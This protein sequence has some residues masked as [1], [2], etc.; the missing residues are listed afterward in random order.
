MNDVI[1][2]DNNE[3][4]E[5]WLYGDSKETEEIDKNNENLLK[6]DSPTIIANENLEDTSDIPYITSEDSGNLI[7]N[8]F[9]QNAALEVTNIELVEIQYAQNNDGQHGGLENGFGPVDHTDKGL[10]GGGEG[11]EEEEEE[12]D[13]QVTIRDIKANPTQYNYP[14][15]GM[16]FNKSL[17][18]LPGAKFSKVG[19]LDL[20]EIGKFNNIPIYDVNLEELED[21]PWRKPGADITD[22]FNYGFTEETWKL[23]SEKQ[24]NMRT[25][26]DAFEKIRHMIPGE[27]MKPFLIPVQMPMVNQPPGEISNEIKS[28]KTDLNASTYDAA[29]SNDHGGLTTIAPEHAKETEHRFPPPHQLTGT[30]LYQKHGG[31]QMSLPPVSF[32]PT[33]PPPSLPPISISSLPP[34]IIPHMNIPPPGYP[35]P[36]FLQPD[37]H[38]IPPPHHLLSSV[39]P[40]YMGLPPPSVHHPLAGLAPRSHHPSHHAPYYDHLNSHIRPPRSYRPARRYYYGEEDEYKEE[41][42]AFK[43]NFRR[44]REYEE[45]QRRKYSKRRTRKED[46]N[47]EGGGENSDDPNVNA[48]EGREEKARKT[49]KAGSKQGEES[50]EEQDRRPE[51][52]DVEDAEEVM[53]KREEE[54]PKKPQKTRRKAATEKDAAEDDLEK[55][56]SEISAADNDDALSK[57]KA[58]PKRST[59]ADEQY[60]EVSSKE[61]SEKRHRDRSEVE[62]EP[63]HRHNSHYYYGPPAHQPTQYSS[64]RRAGDY[65]KHS[66]APYYDHSYPPP[67]PPQ[68]VHSG[69]PY[70][71]DSYQYNKPIVVTRN[72]KEII[73]SRRTRDDSRQR[74]S[75]RE[76]RSRS[77]GKHKKVVSSSHRRSSSK[78]RSK[79]HKEKS[80]KSKRS[81]SEDSGKHH[82]RKRARKKERS[83]SSSSKYNKR[84]SKKYESRSRR[85][86]DDDYE[87]KSGKI[88]SSAP[89]IDKPRTLSKTKLSLEEKSATSS[90]P[91]SNSTHHKKSENISSNDAKTAEG[92]KMGKGGKKKVN[93]T[94]SGD[95]STTSSE[96]EIS[97]SGSP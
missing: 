57:S 77:H 79:R 90:G 67:E 86:Y 14:F 81:V 47:E 94:S 2:K 32:D 74:R 72:T 75:K 63:I 28:E 59:R 68:M 23:Y 8:G 50:E 78:K 76:S 46:E 30:P 56:G 55:S 20:E 65:F 9:D 13:V 51:E 10:N 27:F 54:P 93:E 24:K 83:V 21:K 4:D 69:Q 40:Q 5:A 1:I 22:Y 71:Y 15:K 25:E 38:F 7:R 48:K 87:R 3:D 89:D 84:R 18:Q 95:G 53:G 44:D 35:P 19:T 82:E 60:S 12:D 17:S 41:R 34:S 11:M 33:V 31:P 85:D 36:A 88:I 73:P 80:S 66:N 62:R 39:P 37:G 49:G 91:E 92:K 26:N 61:R 6:P 29:I 58:T 96:E 70:P 97:Q 45:E 64:Y 43:R 16:P 52:E 42:E